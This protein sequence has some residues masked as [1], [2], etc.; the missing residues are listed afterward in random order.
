[1]D[2]P[3]NDRHRLLK[4]HSAGQLGSEAPSHQRQS[5]LREGRQWSLVQSDSESSRLSSTSREHSLLQIKLIEKNHSLL[6]HLGQLHSAR[7]GAIGKEL[8]KTLGLAK[9]T[10]TH[11]KDTTTHL[12]KTAEVHGETLKALDSLLAQA[13]RIRFPD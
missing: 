2:P 10:E 1:M 6:K 4:Q 11:L 3:I 9:S 8:G 13:E 12:D 7:Y 5:L